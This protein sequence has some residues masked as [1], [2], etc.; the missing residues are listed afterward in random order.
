MSYLKCFESR[1]K[2][3]VVVSMGPDDLFLE[4][5]AEAA[6]RADIHTGIVQFG[7]G[8]LKKACFTEGSEAKEREGFFQLFNFT[9]LIASY[10]PHIHVTMVDI[11]S[12]ELMGGHLNDGSIVGSVVECSILRLPDL[13]LVSEYRDGSPVKLL[14]AVKE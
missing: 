7:L 12:G 3:V 1:E 11:H 8:G 2:D 5:I 13:R 14:D 6:R 10:L 9:G 4:G